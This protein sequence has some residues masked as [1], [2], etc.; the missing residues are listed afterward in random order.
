M[1]AASALRQTTRTGSARGIG[2]MRPIV[3]KALEI[4]EL[5]FYAVPKIFRTVF[6]QHDAA[7]RKDGVEAKPGNHPCAHAG[8][9]SPGA[10]ARNRIG[11]SGING[12]AT[13]REMPRMPQ[14]EEWEN[15]ASREM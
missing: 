3:D 14:A 13:S 6:N 12:N 9:M 2:A 1:S 7:K 11:N 4:L 5:G 10:Q 15:A 8:N